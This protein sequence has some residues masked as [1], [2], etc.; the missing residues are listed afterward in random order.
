M[1][2]YII[3]PWGTAEQDLEDVPA[4]LTELAKKV[5][6]Y[7]DM[8]VKNMLMITSKP[9]KGGAI[10]R[11]DTDKG[12]R[13]L[14]VLHR[15]PERSLFS[16][17]AQEYVVN[18]GAR[19][20]KLIRSKSGDNCVEAGGK[21][22][23][24]TDWI[25]LTPADQT[26]I[27]GFAKLCYGLGEFHHHSKGYYPPFGAKFSSRL[28]NYPKQYEKV[29]TKIGW[30][31]ELARA[32]PETL[33]S[34]TLL[35][36]VDK[37]QQ[38]AIKALEKLNN[39]SYYDLIAKGEQYWGLAHQ[40]YGF[41]NGQIGPKGVWIID[42]DGV[43][44]DLPIRD[45]RKLVTSSMEDKGA[46][47]VNW[48]NGMIQ[49]YNQANPISPQLFEVF[50]TDMMLP[51]EFYK[52][53]KEIIFNPDTAMNEELLTL[54]SNIESQDA[55]KWTALQQ[56]SKDWKV[57][58]KFIPKNWEEAFKKK[59]P[60]KYAR[61]NYGMSD[62]LW[63][64]LKQ[65]PFREENWKE[66]IE[67]DLEKSKQTI[68]EKVKDVKKQPQRKWKKYR[69]SIPKRPK[70]TLPKRP[71][72]TLPQKYKKRKLTKNPRKLP[73]RKGKRK[74]TPI[75]SPKKPVYGTPLRKKYLA[76]KKLKKRRRSTPKNF[77]GRRKK[78]VN[79][80]SRKRSV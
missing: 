58:G 15:T 28:H 72:K 53:V 6:K 50:H 74:Y 29:I 75:R 60:E 38:Q 79:S 56:L 25:D 39:T 10:W 46:W 66:N 37:Y 7:Y 59:Y 67:K 24:V 48:M 20:P 71:K 47:D 9:D 73:L 27:E 4:E 3:Q 77:A 80:L 76:E 70:K 61:K 35:K 57:G 14:K 43:S 2:E 55:T 40:D 42:L 45:L 69:K 54:L 22:W 11:I 23:I 34:K 63:E 12:A 44:F 68:P 8:K 19:V 33:A 31:R 32:Y 21:L 52:H 49:A 78:F 5:T 18:Q 30:F 13:S 17:G 41:S 26:S 1:S 51:N 64:K 36:M 65:Q 16:V 62:K